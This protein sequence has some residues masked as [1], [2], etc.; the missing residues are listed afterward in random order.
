MNFQP[1]ID[2]LEAAWDIDGFLGHVRCGEFSLGEAHA[3][4]AVLRS[5]EIRDEELVPKRLLSLLW[6]LPSFLDW[7]V[8]RVTENR[9][10]RSTYESFVT[11]VRN[12]LEER[13]GVP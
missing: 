11:E 9:G 2:R 12:V 8:D 13:I 10:D 7:Q 4:L 5:I 3:F 1:L 6:Y